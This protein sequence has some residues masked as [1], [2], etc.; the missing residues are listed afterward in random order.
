MSGR[1]R[2]SSGKLP[3]KNRQ[4]AFHS[5]LSISIYPAE[6]PDKPTNPPA[7]F[8]AFC[9][10]TLPF[11]SRKALSRQPHCPVRFIRRNVSCPGWRE[12]FAG[13]CFPPVQ[14]HACRFRFTPRSFPPRDLSRQTRFSRHRQGNAPACPRFFSIYPKVLRIIAETGRKNAFSEKFPLPPLLSGM[15]GAL[16][17]TRHFPLY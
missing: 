1:F 9:P 14:A 3:G 15:K 7:G 12:L 11:S 8:S 4:P 6:A 5:A 17:R 13:S 2:Q 10:G 16:S